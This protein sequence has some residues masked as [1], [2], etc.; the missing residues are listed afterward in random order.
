MA[1]VAAIKARLDA[2]VPDPRTLAHMGDTLGYAELAA[3]IG[4]GPRFFEPFVTL[5]RR[6]GVQLL[7]ES[8]PGLRGRFSKAAV[9]KWLR[10]GT[11]R[12][13]ETRRKGA[14]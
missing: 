2:P 11:W 4:R 12:L 5:Q 1:D 6:T 3:L 9:E 7:P 10:H 8:L 13:H 14:A